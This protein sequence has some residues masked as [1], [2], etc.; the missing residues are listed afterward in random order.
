APRS[1]PERRKP[2]APPPTSPVRGQVLDA[3]SQ[4]PLAARLYIR[5]ANGSWYFPDS[6]ATNG[7]AVPYQVRNWIN[8]NAVE[9]HT[10]LSPHPFQ[11]ELPPGRYTF[12]AARGQEY[13]PD[14][15]ELIVADR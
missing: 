9:M 4:Q 14:T 1:T 3:Q 6:A 8:T 12:T 2:F 11:I 5:R 13:F 15:R 7:T 10:T